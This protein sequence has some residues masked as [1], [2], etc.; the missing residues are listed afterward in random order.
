MKFLPASSFQTPSFSKLI[1]LVL[2]FSILAVSSCKKEEEDPPVETKYLVEF[3]KVNNYSA[4]FIKILLGSMDMVYPGIDTLVKDVEY[5]I[6]LYSIT[7]KTKYK[8][9]EIIAS[10][11]VSL[12]ASDKSFPMVSFQNG[13]NTFKLNAPTINPSDPLYTLLEMMASH[14]YVVC[15][16]D[17]IGF[18]STG[19]ILHPYYDKASTNQAVMDM[20]L[21]AGELLK[22]KSVKAESNGKSFFMG[23]SQG[24]WATLA[25]LKEAEQNFSTQLDVVAA[26]CGAGAYDL[27]AMSEH[28]L[29]LEYFPGPLYL[30][31]FIYSR[32]QSGEFS[33]PLSLFFKEPY[34]GRIPELFNGNYTNGEVNEQL[35]DTIASLVTDALRTEWSTSPDFASLRSSMTNNSLQAWNPKA[36]IRFYHGT[37]DRN[38][39]PVQSDI[40]FNQFMDLGVSTSKV[41]LIPMPEATHESGLMPWG[42]STIL[43]F[44]TLKE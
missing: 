28:V 9:A 20:L 39:P 36:T 7:Y 30:P 31:Y 2:L 21:A 5:G 17:Y 26:S 27:T 35:T 19:N 32:I 22:D 8:G 11:L 41:S 13:T 6:D 38:V 23:Y 15:I 12:P 1:A 14:G 10:G 24:G 40:I 37:A 34:A 29:N 18:G 16:P 4:S 33:Q 25:A 42:I 44:D 3:E 43:W